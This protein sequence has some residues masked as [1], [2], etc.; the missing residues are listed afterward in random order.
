MLIAD[1]IRTRAE[2]KFAQFAGEFR[3]ESGDVELR[4]SDLR[5]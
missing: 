2:E 3:L 5:F 1:P 4:H